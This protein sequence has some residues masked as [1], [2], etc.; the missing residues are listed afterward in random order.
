MAGAEEGKV[1]RKAVGEVAGAP[2][3]AD[4]NDDDIRPSLRRGKQDRRSHCQG[5]HY[6]RA[7]EFDT[8]H[9]NPGAPYAEP[10]LSDIIRMA[11]PLCGS[12]AQ[13]RPCLSGTI[14]A[15]L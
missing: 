8:P 15:A 5:A 14:A 2:G 11:D 4:G 12:S 13:R 6:A 10:D 1:D 7:H 9:V 3:V